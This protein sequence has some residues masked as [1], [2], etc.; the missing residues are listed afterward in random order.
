MK[1]KPYTILT[2]ILFP[3]KEAKLDSRAIDD[4]QEYDIYILPELANE[5][6]QEQG[7]LN[8]QTEANVSHAPA[9]RKRMTH[10][11]RTCE[12]DEKKRLEIER[13]YFIK[14]GCFNNAVSGR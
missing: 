6:P 4:S 7:H 12:K 9:E 8:C 14:P 1:V 5:I 11:E 3:R 13:N 10:A 2:R